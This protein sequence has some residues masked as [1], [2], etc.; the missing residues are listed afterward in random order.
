MRCAW[1]RC[2]R[3]PA[4]ELLNARLEQ[5]GYYGRAE[6]A[7]G[8]VVL[9][10]DD[11]A[12]RGIRG[13]DQRVQVEIAPGGFEETARPGGGDTLRCSVHLRFGSTAWSVGPK[14]PAVALRS[15]AVGCTHPAFGA[16]SMISSASAEYL[17]TSA[18]SR[19]P[20]SRWTP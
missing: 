12:A 8:M 15:P 14:R 2:R 1:R 3:R 19:Q 7:L 17:A 4:A 9:G 18:S 5:C 13:L 16:G 6:T 11:P 10:D 20:A